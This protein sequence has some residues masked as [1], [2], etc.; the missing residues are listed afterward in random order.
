MKGKLLVGMQFIL[1]GMLAFTP[2]I[3]RGFGATIASIILIFASVVLLAKSFRDLGDALTPLPESKAGATLVTTGIYGRVRHPIY[4]A[5]FILAA[6]VVIWKQSWQSISVSLLL[7]VLLFYK[8]RYE[9]SLLFLK[10][11]EAA[12]YQSSTPAFF[13]HIK[14]G[15]SR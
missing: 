15:K 6:G 13:P 11:P 14:R 9:D 5:L 10:F 1:L 8:S 12:K 3:N 7:V 2:S 4:S